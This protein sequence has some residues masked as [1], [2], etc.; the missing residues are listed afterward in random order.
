MGSDSLLLLPNPSSWHRKANR[1]L[2][3]PV[4]EIIFKNLEVTA[5]N[6]IIIRC[7]F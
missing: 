6:V 7:I 1:F 2:E 3:Q 5:K 4:L